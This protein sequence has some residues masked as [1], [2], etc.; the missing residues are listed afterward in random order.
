MIQMHNPPHPGEVLREWLVSI[1]VTEAAARLDI[2]RV[3]LS[4]L[5]NG[6]N[7][8]SADM[9]VRLS[10]ALGTTPGYWLGLQADYDLWQARRHF[11]GRVRPIIK[12]VA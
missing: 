2:A 5:L 3:S 9:D 7:G 6:A 11:K 8:I 10:R 12:S 1:T 4:R